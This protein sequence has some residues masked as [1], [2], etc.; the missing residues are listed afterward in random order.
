MGARVIK[1]SQ[2]HKTGEGHIQA[3]EASEISSEVT[4]NRD[5]QVA[6]VASASS[7]SHWRLQGKGFQT[8]RMAAEFEKVKSLLQPSPQR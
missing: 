1:A 6:G 5:S 7:R 3:S 4:L 8:V 2:V